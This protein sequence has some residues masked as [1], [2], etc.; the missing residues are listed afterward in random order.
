M[1]D[2]AEDRVPPVAGADRRAPASDHAEVGRTGDGHAMGDGDTGHWPD[3]GADGFAG[4][5]GEDDGFVD[6]GAFA[7]P[8]DARFAAPPGARSH[9]AGP[10]LGGFSRGGSGGGLSGAAGG[11]LD[12]MSLGRGLGGFG[13]ATRDARFGA[14][15]LLSLG[16]SVLWLLLMAIFFMFMGVPG[17]EEGADPL[18]VV[19]TILVVFA[20]VALIFAA[21]MAAQAARV[22]REET[23]RLSERIETLAATV[24]A[25]GAGPAPTP[26]FTVPPALEAKLADIAASAKKTESAI[27][28]F[29]SVRPAPQQPRPA[30]AAPR[31]A[32]PE[33]QPRLALDAE[34]EAQPLARA[35]FI[36]A[37]QFPETP[38][39]REGFRALRRA[40]AD[41]Q[42][43]QLIQAAQ[44]VLT[45][46][47][48]DGVY[49]D[50][51]PPDRARPELWRRFAQ[52]ERGRA[53]GA[54]GGIRDRE[55]LAA[56]ADRMRADTIFRD[57]AH[58]FL[59][60]FDHAFAAF[61]PE[62]TDSE[63]AALT[64]TRTARAF[65]L[66]GRVAGIFD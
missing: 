57:T 35:D 7:D 28:S 13:F 10:A 14:A 49:M 20:P 33:A 31:S 16:L 27:A 41:R 8:G 23:A 63:I 50:D 17:P 56:S 29:A 15:E 9:P 46:L 66:L 47:S 44:D 32:P 21:V 52:G 54:L 61:E 45:L 39:D 60:K 5:R 36:A 22:V 4:D 59:R 24:G 42:A 30:Q 25:P 6:D 34:G 38:E 26:V 40:L 48:Q 18:R 62:A 55:A 1:T 53:I 65:M 3:D 37:L 12:R 43:A 64:D 2:T 51:L 11:L 58:H 19:V